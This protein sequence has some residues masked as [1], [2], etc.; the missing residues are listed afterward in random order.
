MKERAIVAISTPLGSGGIAII[1]LSGED[2]LKIAR[3][4]FFNEEN[5]Y[6]PDP[7]K[8]YLGEFRYGYVTEKC[9]LVYFKAPYSFTGEDVVEFQIHGGEL[10]AKKVLEACIERGAT[11][12][13]P[14]EFSKRAFL[15]GKISL[16]EAEG[17]T[18]IIHA[19]S[20]AELRAGLSRAKGILYKRSCEYQDIIKEVLAGI[21]VSFDYPENDDEQT[22][23]EDMLKKVKVI[24]TEID[25]IVE[26]NKNSKYIRTGISV[27]IAGKP[28]VGKSSLLN[29]LLG[30]DR[31]IVTEIAGTTR[32]SL[33]E[34]VLYK[35]I[36]FNF[37]DTAGIRDSKDVVENIGIKKSKEALRESDVVLVLLDATSKLSDED[38]EILELTKNKRRIIV[39]NKTDRK[40]VLEK[41]DN[42]L[43]ISAKTGK[44]TEELL[45]SIHDMVLG[46]NL[47]QSA[48]LILNERVLEILKGI[49]I[50]LN[51]ILKDK[52]NTL[53][54]L[55]TKLKKVY[56]ELGKISGKTEN[57]DIID[58]IFSKFCLGK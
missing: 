35:G 11:L 20:E 17:I 40:R 30:E 27:A 51:E 57:E 50:L 14:G 45:K 9:L 25:E 24:R 39:I 53:D 12:A 38:K 8:L 58:L 22:T 26:K 48:S 44:N 56:T 29:S 1:R 33:V 10:L 15:N 13:E 47:D 37:I 2:S 7:R 6:K 34:T 36:K 49:S 42:E 3:G 52:K 46:E 28:N 55:E 23:K 21:D 43:S 18:D 41:M 31:A 54:L 19:S 32:D 4:L 16:D 5:L